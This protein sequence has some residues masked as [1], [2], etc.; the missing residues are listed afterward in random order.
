MLKHLLIQNYALIDHLDISFFSGFSAI[1]GETG[2]GKSILMD[3]LDLVLGKR[4]DSQVLLDPQ[5]K[6]IVE[7]TFDMPGKHLASFFE[8]NNLDADDLI[9]LRREITAGGKSRAFINDTPVNLSLLRALG[10]HLVDIHAQ[11][12]TTSLQDPAFQLSVIDSFAGTEDLL[13]QYQEKYRLH[14]KWQ[15]E[16]K[17]L[18]SKEEQ[19]KKTM[20]FQQFLLEELDSANPTDDEQQDLE[21]QLNVFTHAEEIKNTLFHVLQTMTGEEKSV[22]DLLSG[23]E[24]NLTRI[25]GYH[26]EIAQLAERLSSGLIDLREICRDLSTIDQGIDFNA[27]Q[28]SLVQQRLDLI[29]RLQQKH[30]VKSCIE[31][32]RIREDLR[33][34]LQG[35]VSLEDQITH[36]RKNIELLESEIGMLAGNLTE[37]RAGSFLSFSSQVSGLLH[38]M[39]MPEGR[40][41]VVRENT[42]ELNAYGG[43]R[44]DFLFNAN[45]GHSM[46]PIA[47]IAS[48]GELS[49][50]M[51][52]V[53]SLISKKKMLPT[54]VFDE[55]DN[56]LSGDIA[57]R[58]GDILIRMSRGIQ[59]IAITHLPQIAGRADHQYTVYK[60]LKKEVTYSNIRVLDKEERLTELARMIG[61]KET[62]AASVAAARELL[63]PAAGVPKLFENN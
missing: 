9:I 41:E 28:L 19:A 27:D 30:H 53:K 10:D 63:L 62:T 26:S 25:S 14:G 38:H 20:D 21:E 42:P 49:R 45:K 44:I 32:N 12:S 60:E 57:G 51:L 35:I 13:G 50:V 11:N 23:A 61:G 43:D 17:E 2:A 40:F 16:L 33:T 18:I 46:K 1:T 56:G 31:L 8:A 48:G 15:A 39:G 22:T 24:A 3:A 7:G 29:Y 5:R 52:G 54:V 37:K 36:L 34:E 58:V 47:D 6:C 4:A 59:V 55:I